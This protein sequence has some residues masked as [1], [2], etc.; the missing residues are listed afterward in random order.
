M[1]RYTPIEVSDDGVHCGECSTRRIN[2][3]DAFQTSLA[4]DFDLPDYWRCAGCLSKAKEIPSDNQ[5]RD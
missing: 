1:I 3:C 4:L 2:W 5:P